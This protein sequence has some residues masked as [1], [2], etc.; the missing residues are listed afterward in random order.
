[1]I[2]S[3]V[4]ILLVLV[5]GGAAGMVFVLTADGEENQS[6]EQSLDEMVEYSFQTEEMSTDLEDGSFVRI[7]FQ[8]VADSEKAKEEVE[9]REFQTQNI[10]IK[11]LAK[12]DRD[13]FKEGLSNLESI[14]KDK[15]NEVMHEGKIVDVYTIQKVLQ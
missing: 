5:I 2:K 15:L 13:A 14:M 11:E 7:Q 3:L 1:M 6:D 12:M 10:L 9:K 8:I 4:V